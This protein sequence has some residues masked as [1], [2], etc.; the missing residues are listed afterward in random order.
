MEDECFLELFLP[1]Y[2]M[3][4]SSSTAHL[5]GE[6]PASISDSGRTWA[7]RIPLLEIV[8]YIPGKEFEY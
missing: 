3:E 8:L 6:R 2:P 4:A 1:A 7:H 5:T